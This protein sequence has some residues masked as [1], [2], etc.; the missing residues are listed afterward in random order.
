MS[1]DKEALDKDWEALE[2]EYKEWLCKQPEDIINLEYPLRAFILTKLKNQ[3]EEY[4]K[5]AKEEERIK[6]ALSTIHPRFVCSNS[7]FA[8]LKLY[9]ELSKK[10][11]AE[12]S[13]KEEMLKAA[14]YVVK[15]LE[16][17]H[18]YDCTKATIEQLTKA[19]ET[20]KT[21]TNGD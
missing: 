18:G 13:R 6:A 9:F 16:F 8:S 3:A 15:L 1:E 12:L 19:R 11:E 14:D 20:Y 17:V 5:E 2:D 21:L 4:E 7:E 10:L